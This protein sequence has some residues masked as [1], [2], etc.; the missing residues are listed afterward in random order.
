M[1]KTLHVLECDWCGFEASDSYDEDKLPDGWV[2]SH[3]TLNGLLCP[4][5]VKAIKDT[6]ASCKAKKSTAGHD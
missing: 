1:R 3:G 5:C 6:E 2:D 4:S